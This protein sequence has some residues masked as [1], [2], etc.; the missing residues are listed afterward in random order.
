MLTEDDLA[1]L[2]QYG[3]DWWV[4]AF[5]V[6]GLQMEMAGDAGSKDQGSEVP[7]EIIRT[8]Y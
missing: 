6:N 1:L 2:N 8:E 3:L 4:D 7:S 5:W